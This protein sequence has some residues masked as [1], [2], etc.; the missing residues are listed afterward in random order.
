[1][2]ICCNYKE[3][4]IVERIKEARGKYTDKNLIGDFDYL[5]SLIEDKL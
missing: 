4:G 5:D 3:D 2:D 1:M